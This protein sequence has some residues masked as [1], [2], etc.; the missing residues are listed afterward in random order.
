MI[1]IQVTCPRAFEV[2]LKRRRKTKICDI[3]PK[4]FKAKKAWNRSFKL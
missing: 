1:T 3:P 2:G 4:N